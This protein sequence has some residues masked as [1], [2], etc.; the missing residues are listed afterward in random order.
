MMGK[1][2]A[3]VKDVIQVL[4][5]PCY[6]VRPAGRILPGR[7]RKDVNIELSRE[8]MDGVYS[9]GHRVH[10]GKDSRDIVEVSVV[11]QSGRFVNPVFS[12]AE[13]DKDVVH[14]K[15]NA[16]HLLIIFQA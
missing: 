15:V 5:D 8:T 11:F 12:G 6:L 4:R 13:V 9:S 7:S 1:D 2:Q 16:F 14:V 3:L 10:Q